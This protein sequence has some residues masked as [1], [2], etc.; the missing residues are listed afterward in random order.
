MDLART[1]A[2]LR[3]EEALGYLVNPETLR[4]KDG[5]SAAIAILDLATRARAEGRDL[6]DMLREFGDTFRP[7]R[8]RSD[9]PALRR[10][11]YGVGVHG[12]LR[13]EPPIVVAE[14]PVARFED[15][16][17]GTDDLPPGDVLRFQLAD[18]SRILVR[19]SGTEPKLKAYVAARADSAAEAAARLSALSADVRALLTTLV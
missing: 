15:L 10:R 16:R 19:P 9:L 3:Y 7:L 14:T 11:G 17:E 6:S 4:D 13:A 2:V 5:L 8:K 12:R 1:R 18:G